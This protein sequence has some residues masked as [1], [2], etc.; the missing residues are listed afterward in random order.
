[1][2]WLLVGPSIAG[3]QINQSGDSSVRIFSLTLCPPPREGRGAGCWVY[4]KWPRWLN[5][6]CLCNWTSIVVQSLSDVWLFAPPWT[7]ALQ[8]PLSSTIFQSLLKL[9]SINTSELWP[10]GSFHMPGRC[11][12][13]T[14]QGQTFL[15]LGP[16]QTLPCVP[17]SLADQLTVSFITP[18]MRNQEKEV[19]CFSEFCEP[20]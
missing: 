10:S 17:L 19:K 9:T 8:S 7:I 12:T 16:I 11:H 6:P 1:M 20:I 3:Y 14:P 15:C 18:F 13:W 4:H 5:Q 2:R